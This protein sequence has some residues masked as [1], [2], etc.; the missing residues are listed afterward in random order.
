MQHANQVARTSAHALTLR[1]HLLA[2]LHDETVLLHILRESIYNSD[3][4][5]LEEQKQCLQIALHCVKNN[6]S[7]IPR[8]RRLTQRIALEF[9]NIIM[10]RIVD[11]TVR[12][13]HTGI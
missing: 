6:I 5:G 8:Q 12:N 9:Q 4:N 1:D 11:P 10:R 13:Q 2:S 7:E 3:I